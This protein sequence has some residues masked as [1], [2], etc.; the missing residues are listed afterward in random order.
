MTFTSLKR[1]S[2]SSYPDHSTWKCL[3]S[4]GQSCFALCGEK[5]NMVGLCTDQVMAAPSGREAVNSRR[6]SSRSEYST[7]G[8]SSEWG[9]GGGHDSGDGRG[10][11]AEVAA[12]DGREA[13][14]H[15][16]EREAE[17]PR[18]VHG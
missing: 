4:V 10:P 5:P 18:P 7:C 11:D 12:P 6:A 2:S 14:N 13:K 8:R 1:L 17:R 16:G 3:A 15:G 9:G